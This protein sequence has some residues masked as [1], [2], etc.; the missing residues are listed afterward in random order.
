M[1]EVGAI[2]RDRDRT[3]DISARFD[4]LHL[5]ALGQRD[6]ME[7]R[8]A[9]AESGFALEHRRR[10]VDVI[11]GFINPI[12]L[13]CGGIDAVQLEIVAADDDV[14]FQ[15]APHP[16]PLPIGWGEGVRRTGEG[17]DKPVRR[18]EDFVAGLIFPN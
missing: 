14:C 4:F 11:A 12:G 7:N 5:L 2:V 3:G 10:A 13:A 18:T 6:H 8:V 15:G 1:A 16:F 17:L 9:A